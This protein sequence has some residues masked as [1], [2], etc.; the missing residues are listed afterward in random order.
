MA[1]ASLAGQGLLLVAKGLIGGVGLVAY[2]LAKVAILT[3]EAAVKALQ[4][5]GQAAVLV[6]TQLARG[7]MAVAGLAGRLIVGAGELVAMTA[8]AIARAAVA[9]AKYAVELAVAARRALVRITKERVVHP[10]VRGL[11]NCLNE[12]DDSPQSPRR[13][14][15]IEGHADEL[16]RWS[17]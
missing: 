5:G 3:A 10:C 16:R 12:L 9:A 8:G 2:G 17:R 14:L 1:G 6:A 11:K 4:L 7:A 15:Q 13:S